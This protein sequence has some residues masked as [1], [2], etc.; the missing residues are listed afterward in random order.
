MKQTQAELAREG[1]LGALL[2]F[3]CADRDVYK[4]LCYA[5]DLGHDAESFIEDVLEVSSLAH[6]D[7][8]YEQAAARWELA[9]AYLLEE[10]GLE[11]DAKSARGHLEKALAEFPLE[12][13]AKATKE[14][15]D[16]GAVLAA[17][18]GDRKALLE[19]ALAD[20]PYHRIQ[21]LLT[22]FKSLRKMKSAPKPML[23][24][25]AK[26]LTAEVRDL[27]GDDLEEDV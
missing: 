13:I 11:F 8:G 16:A 6:D 14:P 7:D 5:A 12:E 9:V 27:L 3:E 22:V 21:H 19:E 10:D 4:W 20:A 18:S 25:A 2:D 26:T 23:A 15:Y 1:E 17:L 24:Y